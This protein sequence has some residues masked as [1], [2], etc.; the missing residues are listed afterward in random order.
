M[1]AFFLVLASYCTNSVA[2]IF[3]MCLSVGFS[4]A[5]AVG[6]DVNILDI[7]AKYA[8]ILMGFCNTIGALT[9]FISPM[10]AGVLTSNKVGFHQDKIKLRR[11]H[12]S[13]HRI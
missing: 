2:V 7:A 9:G 13:F 5:A 3:N 12:Q 1:S 4:G 6:Y 11:V 10:L 8:G